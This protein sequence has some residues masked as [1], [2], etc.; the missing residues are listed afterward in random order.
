LCRTKDDD[1][2]LP[3]RTRG[4]AEVLAHL[5]R[6]RSTTNG[7]FRRSSARSLLNQRNQLGRG[8]DE[9]DRFGN[10]EHECTA[11]VSTKIEMSLTNVTCPVSGREDAK[12]EGNFTQ[13][14]VGG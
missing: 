5:R 11:Y 2:R 7:R 6:W 8:I 13:F 9:Q 4:I 14:V 10:L 1:G 12:S 3:P